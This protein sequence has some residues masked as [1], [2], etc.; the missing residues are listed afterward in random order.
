MDGFIEYIPQK[1]KGHHANIVRV[2][3]NQKALDILERYK[4][5]DEAPLP[6][7]TLINYNKRIKRILKAEEQLLNQHLEKQKELWNTSL[8]RQRCNLES[9]EG[10]WFSKKAFHTWLWFFLLPLYYTI[11]LICYYLAMWFG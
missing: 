2:P 5:L 8:A 9:N 1:T 11:I 10:I 7:F 3:L 4:E 6:C